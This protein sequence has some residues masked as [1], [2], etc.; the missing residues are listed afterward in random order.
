M[1]GPPPCS[2]EKLEGSPSTHNCGAPHSSPLHLEPE[3]AEER[4]QPQ[5]RGATLSQL[6]DSGQTLS[7][8]SGVDIAEAGG[9]SKD[10]SPRPGK[11]P[12]LQHIGD[13]RRAE[14][15]AQISAK[16][17]E[18][19][20]PTHVRVPKCA[21]TLGIA[22]EGGANTRQPMPRIVTIQKGGSAHISGLLRVGQVILEVNGVSLRGMEH[23]DATR[24]IAEAFKTKDK[25]HVDFLIAEFNAA[26]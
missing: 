1:P 23:R 4:P 12:F 21:S 11:P 22:V 3:T 14:G 24:V 2:P 17:M 15:L 9:L 7:E 5:L 25:D 8:D 20:E 16:Q 26:L 19:M 10:S 6:S 18:I 13:A